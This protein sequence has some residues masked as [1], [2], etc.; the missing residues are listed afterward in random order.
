MPQTVANMAGIVK[1]A[2]TSDTLV[3][4]FYNKNPLIERIKTVKA[5]TIGLQ[6]QTPIHSI[7]NGGYTSVGPAGG[8]LNPA[9]QQG[10]AQ[11][12]WTLVY[13]YGQ[14]SLETAALNQ[15]EGASQSV[16]SATDLEV[17]GAIDDVSRQMS[18]QIASNGDSL[19]AQC[20]VT[21]ASTVVVLTPAAAGG[22]GFDA[23]RR[24]HIYIGQIVDIGI[25]ADSDSAAT[26]LTIQDV[27]EDPVTPT[28]T[29]SSAVTTSA[30]HF[31][32]IAN[33]NSAT[34][35][36]VEMNGLRNIAGSNGTLGGIN[37]ATLGNGF[38]KPALID[39]TTTAVSLDLMLNLQAAVFQKRGDF[40]G[41]FFTSAKQQ[42][43]VYALLQNQVRF[44]GKEGLNAG[45]VQGLEWNGSVLNILP[46]VYDKD[47]FY[48]TLDDLTRVV[49][50]W[51]KPMWSSDIEGAGGQFRWTQGTTSYGESV[52]WAWQLG[53]QRRNSMAA[54][55]SLLA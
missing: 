26:G 37:P 34:A 46:D 8:S 31:V 28:I 51:D 4:Q 33:P 7:R 48:V 55:V 5:T 27:N 16:I 45:G 44:T 30:V 39:T 9:G 41:T 11:A 32:S 49:G 18:R 25:L 40:T 21:T 3:K 2:W 6:A 1:D 17:Q 24:G 50:A 19:M 29:V 20:G 12:L 35:P 52:V 53:C 14:V 47:L 43:S 42:A 23:I 36:N 38:W 10:T 13:H 54:A 15:T 22:L